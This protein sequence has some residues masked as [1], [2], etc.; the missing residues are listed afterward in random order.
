MTELRKSLARQRNVATTTASAN[1]HLTNHQTFYAFIAAIQDQNW[2]VGEELWKHLSLEHKKILAAARR[3]ALAS[4]G[5]GSRQ[6]G[7]SEQGNL[8]NFATPTNTAVI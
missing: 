4:S 3:T 5:E 8:P 7:P 2:R 6:N 1:A